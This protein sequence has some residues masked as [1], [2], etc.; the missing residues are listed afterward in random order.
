[1]WKSKN[2]PHIQ[3][4]SELTSATDGDKSSPL[5]IL[6]TYL[7]IFGC[8]GSSLLC[9]GFLQL[10]RVG[11]TLCCSALASRCGGLS[12]CGAWALGAQASVV[13]ARR[14]SSCGLQALE[15]K[16][17]SCSA[18]A[19]LLRGMWDLPRPGL[20]PVSSALAGRFLT[21][22]PPGKPLVLCLEI[23]TDSENSLDV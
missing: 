20:E 18:R 7:F 12:C 5:F 8:I 15:H 6:F 17:S 1:M 10:W 11:T 14:L 3:L 4:L 16:L 19:Q 23:G 9:A 2:D 21:T 13:V 22:A